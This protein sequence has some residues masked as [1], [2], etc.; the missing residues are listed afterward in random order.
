MLDFLV[1]R[2]SLSALRHATTEGLHSPDAA[3]ELM[4]MVKGANAVL[5]ALGNA[6]TTLNHNSSRFG[7][8]ITLHYEKGAAAESSL[9]ARISGGQISSYL[10]EKVPAPARIGRP[11]AT[12]QPSP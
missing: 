2:S 4:Q 9:S 10:L 8:L 5:E 3:A 11:R 1:W 6:S 12:P 7:K